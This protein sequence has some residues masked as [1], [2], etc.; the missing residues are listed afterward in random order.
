MDHEVVPFE[1]LNRWDDVRIY[2]RDR[3]PVDGII[4]ETTGRA[5][6]IRTSGGKNLTLSRSEIIRIARVARPPR[7]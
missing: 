7:G 6:V 1:D 5:V 3:S 4:V 2:C